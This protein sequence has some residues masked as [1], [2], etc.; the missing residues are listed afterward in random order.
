MINTNDQYQMINTLPPTS[1]P[2]VANA[3]NLRPNWQGDPKF[4]D[5]RRPTL[6]GNPF[7][8][9]SFSRSAA[10]SKFKLYA[11]NSKIIYEN[12]YYLTGKILVCVCGPQN[13]HGD[14]LVDMFLQV[15]EAE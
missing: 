10:I 3:R 8:L 1:P 14:I 15:Y 6:W 11:H 2:V 7:R 4:V 9:N 12:L 5:I 13:C